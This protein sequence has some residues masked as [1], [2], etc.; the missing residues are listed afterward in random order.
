MALKCLN[1]MGNGPPVTT[2]IQSILRIQQVVEQSISAFDAPVPV[3]D[4][5]NYGATLS[6]SMDR[7]LPNIQFPSL[8]RNVTG[9]A[10][11]LIVFTDKNSTFDPNHHPDGIDIAPGADLSTD[12]LWISNYDVLTTDLF[13]FFPTFTS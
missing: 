1:M 6:G 5:D 11:D 13:N 3:P 8:D 4:K 7:S 10:N 9:S 2:A 12:P